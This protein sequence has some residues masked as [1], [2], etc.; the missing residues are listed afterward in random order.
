MKKNIESD[1][2]GNVF[3]VDFDN[4]IYNT[5]QRLGELAGEP[6]TDWNLTNHGLEW[7]V[8]L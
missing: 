7:E 1:T 2:N 4:V 5:N 3:Y 8:I 6:I